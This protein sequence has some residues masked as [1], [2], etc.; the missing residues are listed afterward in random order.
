ME[1]ALAAVNRIDHQ[2]FRL[3]TR[4]ALSGLLSAGCSYFLILVYGR[5][6]F[7][8]FGVAAPSNSFQILCGSFFV[9]A[10][11]V[12]ALEGL[13]TF[14]LKKRPSQDAN[15]TELLEEERVTPEEFDVYYR[16]R[17]IIRCASFL[18][19]L[20]CGALI[21]NFVVMSFFNVFFLSYVLTTLC[22]ILWVRYTGIKRPKL[23]HVT[24]VSGRSRVTQGSSA[25]PSSFN[26]DPYPYGSMLSNQS[27]MSDIARNYLLDYPSYHRW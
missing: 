20:L 22:G 19:A 1:E 10:G 23:L 21:S 7:D 26:Q 18:S 8:F 3:R 24:H 11:V 16:T 27:I 12:S 17:S 4:I 15:P 14:V 13:V 6:F 9:Y 5:T 2:P 25:F